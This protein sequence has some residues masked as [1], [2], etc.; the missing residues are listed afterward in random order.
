MAKPGRPRSLDE[1]KRREICA[2][3][4]AGAGLRQAAQYV[5]CSA[6]TVHREAQRDRDFRERL[7]RATATAQLAPLQSMR[8]A[9][10][11]HWRAAAWMLER[12]NP[13]QFGRNK[14]NSFGAKELRALRRDLL[15]IFDDEIDHPLL[16]ERIAKRVRATVDYAMRHA[17]DTQRT[18]GQLRK[19]ME[20]FANKEAEEDPFANNDPRS[21]F[22]RLLDEL[23]SYSSDQATDESEIAAQNQSSNAK[24]TDYCDPSNQD[25]A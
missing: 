10:Q 22:D 17:W 5:G 24:P 2:V 15:A 8:Q 12:S 3:V 4:T 1:T 7:R 18:G 21:S 19:A 13:E 11:S 6:S 25:V 14:T 20:F 9:A 23:G 16:R